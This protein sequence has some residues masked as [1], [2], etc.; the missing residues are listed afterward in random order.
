MKFIMSAMMLLLLSL[1]LVPADTTFFD[2]DNAF[3][4]GNS[5][6]LP[7]SEITGAASDG[8]TETIVSKG[9]CLTNWS[10][11][12][13]SSCVNE[14]QIRNCTK[15][16]IYCYADLKNKPAETQNCS[17]KIKNNTQVEKE[18]LR[19][20]NLP[21]NFKNIIIIVIGIIILVIVLVFYFFKKYRRKKQI[22]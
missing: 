2:Q 7:I 11:S 6:T 19:S 15:E 3:I 9:S 21:I 12:S 16:K 17:N 13:W 5:A 4:I 20:Q 22:I 8:T 14:I 18:D 10:C 1:S